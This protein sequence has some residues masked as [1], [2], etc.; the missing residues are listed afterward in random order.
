VPSTNQQPH[1]ILRGIK[2]SDESI[3]SMSTFY[4][5]DLSVPYW[6]SNTD[7]EQ[8]FE[9]FAHRPNRARAWL[10]F[11]DVSESCFGFQRAVMMRGHFEG[12]ILGGHTFHWTFTPG[13]KGDLAIVLPVHEQGRL[14]DFVAMSRHDHNIWGCCTGAGQYLGDI[15]TPLRVHRTPANWLANDCDGILPLSKSFLPSLRNAPKL[16]AEDDD[17]A[18]ELAFRVF[19][20]P[21]AAFGSDQGVAESLAYERIE[22]A[23]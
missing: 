16:I 17:H 10:R 4:N 3:F 8:L 12:G 6:R 9:A 7:V 13:R 11:R 23:A 15:T 22:A 5:R 21:A 14:T 18:W 2:S 20:D 19:I 1:F